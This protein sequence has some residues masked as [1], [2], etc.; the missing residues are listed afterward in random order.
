MPSKPKWKGK[1]RGG[2]LGYKIFIFFLKYFG[3]SFAY[4]VLL[5]VAFYFI[6]FAPK[7]TRA[8]YFY[9]HKVQKFGALKSAAFVYW[10]YYR[11]GQTLL[12]KV[13][14]LA[15]FAPKF[16]YQFDGKHHLQHLANQGK[17][18][19]LISAHIGNWEIASH[20]LEKLDTPVNVVMLDAEHQRIKAILDK[21]MTKR[22]FKVIPVKDDFSHLLKIHKA[23]RKKEFICIHGDRYIAAHKSKTYRT[24]F[25]GYYAHFPRGPFELAARLEVPY[26]FVFA[27]K[28]TNKHYHFYAMPGKMAEAGNVETIIEEYLQHMERVLE[29]APEQWF[30]YYDYWERAKEKTE[31][32]FATIESKN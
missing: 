28:E 25:L 19:V 3:I 10:S 4:F 20:F 9:F 17:G 24:R 5:F 11:F 23:V 15:G 32:N 22:A 7:A 21:S 8:S 18:A 30:N 2:V 13:A 29:D 27:I 1:S 31:Q 26:T 14:V 16:T 6:P 12:D